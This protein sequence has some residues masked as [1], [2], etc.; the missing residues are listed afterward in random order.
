VVH[1]KDVPQ[2]AVALFQKPNHPLTVFALHK[3]EHKFT[4]VHFSVNRN[5]EYEEEV[6]SKVCVLAVHL[7]RTHR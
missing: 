6:R 1:L 5:T 7:Q 4:V 3:H 2:E